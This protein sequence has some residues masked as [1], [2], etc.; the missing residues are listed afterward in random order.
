[1]SDAEEEERVE[2]EKESYSIGV[3]L[4]LA[5][6]KHL[7]TDYRPYIQQEKIV[8]TA[9]NIYFI[10]MVN[11][12]LKRDKRKAMMA[13]CA[14]EAY[15][16][17]NMPKDPLLLANKFGITKKKFMKAQGIFYSQLFSM[18]KL[19][20]FPK[21]HFTAIQLL[22]DIAQH[23]QIDIPYS[24][25][26]D[27]IDSMYSSSVFAARWSPRDVAIVVLLW[28]LDKIK[29]VSS[30]DIPQVKAHI[31]QQTSIPETKIKQMSRIINTIVT[32]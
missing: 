14:Y 17:N 7:M 8:E 9:T 19:K 3:D 15:N 2:Y 16:R 5:K 30:N 27:I 20:E 25:L 11:V 18:N 10:V 28:Y 26:C 23:F 32:K 21:I 13:K 24:D 31:K 22:P 4:L 6:R 1:M 29:N 12:T